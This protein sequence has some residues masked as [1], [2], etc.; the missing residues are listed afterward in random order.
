MSTYPRTGMQ[1]VLAGS[2]DPVLRVTL[3]DHDGDPAAAVGTLVCTITRADGTVV[4]TNRAT[5]ASDQTGTY[6][7]ALTAAEALTLDVLTATWSITGITRATSYHRVVGGFLFT[8]VDLLDLGGLTG[9]TQMQLRTARDQVTDLFE[10]VTG[11]CWAPTYDL[12]AFTGRSMPNHVSR[13]RPLRSLRSASIDDT[14]R[15]LTD[16][17]LRGDAGVVGL[18]S[19]SSFYGQCVLGLEHGYDAAPADLADAAMVAAKDRLLRR[20]SAISDRARSITDD[21]GTRTFAYAGRDHPTGIDEVDAV[22]AD[23]DHRTYWIG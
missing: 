13:Y 12:E 21:M 17:E 18:L 9:F 2:V 1:R 5:A 7:V 3:L 16:L 14:T 15:A 22:L 11:V 8:L 6:T 23:H 10:R 20:R 19:G 4:A